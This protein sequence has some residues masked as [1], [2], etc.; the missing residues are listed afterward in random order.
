MAYT[1]GV[2]VARS[3]WN[4][5]GRMAGFTIYSPAVEVETHFPTLKCK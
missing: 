5:G 4:S 1:I 3:D 2:G